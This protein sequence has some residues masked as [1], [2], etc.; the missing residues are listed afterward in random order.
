MW[1]NVPDG[2]ERNPDVIRAEMSVMATPMSQMYAAEAYGAVKNIQNVCAADYKNLC[3][4]PSIDLSAV[5]DFL[6]NFMAARMLAEA[7]PRSEGTATV[8]KLRSYYRDLENKPKVVPKHGAHV[9]PGNLRKV[10]RIGTRSLSQVTRDFAAPPPKDA[11][12][13]S[14]EGPPP[15]KEGPPPRGPPPPPPSG[16]DGENRPP[17]P[18]G[19]PSG[20]GP[21]P[22]PRGPP[23]ADGDKEGRGPPPKPKPAPKSPPSAAAT[24]WFGP[25]PAMGELPADEQQDQQGLPPPP[26]PPGPWEDVFYNG[27]LGFGA[28]GDMC[29]YE[30]FNQLSQPCVQ[31]MADLY[32]VRQRYWND[33]EEYYGGHR[34]FLFLVLGALFVWAMVKKC[35]WRKRI[36]KVR[37][38]MDA[39]NANPALKAT[40]EAETGMPVPELPCG[41][42]CKD[43]GECTVG[44]CCKVF[45]ALVLCFVVSVFIAVTSLEITFNILTNW[46]ADAEAR[47]EEPN[48]TP[49]TAFLLLTFVTLVEVSIFVLAVKVGKTLC[50][51]VHGHSPSSN[52]AAPAPSAPPASPV[53]VHHVAPMPTTATASNGGSR[54][55]QWGRALTVNPFSRMF[56]TNGGATHGEYTAL[57]G[58]EEETEMVTVTP[59]TA[60]AA[61][62]A[63]F[64]TPVLMSNGQ[65]VLVTAAAPVTKVNLV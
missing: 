65:T 19:P 47:G 15:S 56:S 57:S 45:F 62:T 43:K 28:E 6:D 20:Q 18:K 35:I 61:P 50:A 39:I 24:S 52:D 31:G 11:T 42:H 64:L 60:A 10:T 3:A 27:A 32:D 8:G 55:M 9:K 16:E 4:S 13:P 40:I 58:G 63:Q 22:P 36:Q 54:R 46:D 41:H 21:P 1:Y 44:K 30:N 59:G 25:E 38:F 37:T 26:P 12:P 2:L 34:H 29:L 48:T 7:K 33:N 49:T 53:V 51:L 23:P 5:S 17:P 14:K